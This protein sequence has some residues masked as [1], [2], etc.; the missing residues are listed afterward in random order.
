MAHATITVINHDQAYLQ[1]MERFLQSL[2]YQAT[3]FHEGD[4]AFDELRE[5]VP[6]LIIIDIWLKAQ[7]DGWNLIQKVRMDPATQHVPIIVCSSDA[8]SLQA[9]SMVLQTLNCEAL[10]KPFDLDVLQQKIVR[11]LAK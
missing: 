2:G 1:L 8:Q 6:D 10:E 9:K 7:D 4:R 3:C 5:N 11:G